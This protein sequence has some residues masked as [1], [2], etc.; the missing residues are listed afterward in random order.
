MSGTALSP[1][2]VAY[3]KEIGVQNLKP[4]WEAEHI[5]RPREPETI[6]QPVIWRYRDI[7]PILLR[8]GELVTTEQAER[9]VLALCNPGLEGQFWATRTLYAGMQLINPGEI[10]WAHRH[11]Q[12]AMRFIVEGHGAYTTVEGEKV[13][14][15]PGDFVIT[16]SWTWHDHGN[17]GDGPVVWL[18]SL[19]TPLVQ[20]LDSMFR[21]DAPAG[22]VQDQTV[23]VDGSAAR[24]GRGLLPVDLDQG[25]ANSP[26]AKYPY[27]RT[28]EALE[29]MRKADEW[30][31]CQGLKLRYANP[32]SG[33]FV[34]PTI[35]TCIQLLPKGF[36]GAPY[37]ATESVIYVAV[38]GQGRTTIGDAVFDWEPGDVFV[39]PGWTRYRHEASSDAVLFSVTDR[40]VHL[41]LGLWREER[42]N[43]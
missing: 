2:L 35:G 11:T 12:A 39:A 7:R 5:Q 41:K 8:S 30:D 15:A 38:E 17:E 37:R 13:T 33:D 6:V 26:L 21:E 42:G 14:L 3:S 20:H 32:A 4:L 9:R 27:D 22:T 16:P 24:F 29:E 34:M 28:R 19:D 10:A 36:A 23:P 43:A 25:A 1:E 40:P 31:P 18:D